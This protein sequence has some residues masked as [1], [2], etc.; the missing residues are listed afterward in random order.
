MTS[1]LAAAVAVLHAVAYLAAPGWLWG[2][3]T[4][5]PLLASSVV[6]LVF[7]TLLFLVPPLGEIVMAPLGAAAGNR[8]LRVLGDKAVAVVLAG[9]SAV[10]VIWWAGVPEIAAGGWIFHYPYTSAES[11]AS[12]AAAIPMILEPP[13]DWLSGPAGDDVHMI[14]RILCTAFGAAMVCLLVLL[15]PRNRS[16][17][18]SGAA[19]LVVLSGAALVFMSARADLALALAATAAFIALGTAALEYRASHAWAGPAAIVAAMAHP[20][21]LALLPAWAYLAG[22]KAGPDR[23]RLFWISLVGSGAVFLV[24]LAAMELA[25]RSAFSEYVTNVKAVW[26][27]GSGARSGVVAGSAGEGGALKSLLMVAGW[28]LERIWGTFNGLLL[29]APA[30]LALAAAA[31]LSLRRLTGGGRGPVFSFLGFT[32][33]ATVVLA[34]LSSHYAGPPRSWGIYGPAGL[35]MTA[36][37]A[38]WIMEAI[39]DTLRYRAAVLGCVA[40]SLVHLLPV[41]S[42]PPDPELAAEKLTVEASAP[43]PWDL[44]GR[45][46]AFEELGTFHISRGDT[47]AAADALSEA[48]KVRPNPLYLGTAGTYYVTANRYDLAEDRFSRIVAERPFDVEANL[49]LGILRAVKGDMEGAKRRLLFAMGD[50][51]LALAEPEMHTSADWEE[52]PK[53]PAREALIR[54]RAEKRMQA[55]EVFIQGDEAAAKGLLQAA[56]RQYKRALAIYPE[57]GRMQF[58]SHLHLGT[59]YAM[60]GRFREA[61]H[62][63]LLG[64]NSYRDYNLCYYIVNA[65]GYGPSRPRA[66]SA[67]APPSP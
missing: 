36:F 33:L 43:S 48:W 37:G 44:R 55:T 39:R 31:L 3:N 60:Q 38:W 45:A 52:V 21:G 5:Y 53:G 65:V 46:K 62:E 6:G 28:L 47:L 41:L 11:G 14:G 42:I 9:G 66:A 23:R 22:L 8:H 16:S 30:G 63:I 56:E 58:E 27:T 34:F 25:G 12:G 10:A 7:L 18:R 26:A 59:I 57:W 4:L 17:G 40:L 51:T 29:A 54:E 35:C 67:H 19:L 49:S 32:T 64:I 50:T 61:A 13:A 1:G 24:L 20:V 15:P 2:A